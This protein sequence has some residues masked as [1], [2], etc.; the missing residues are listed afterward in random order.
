LQFHDLNVNNNS[1]SGC[2]DL[3][4]QVAG[5]KIAKF[6]LGCFKTASNKV[7]ISEMKY[8]EYDL[9]SF[10]KERIKF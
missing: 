1:F 8:V 6:K 5:V 10:Q 3:I 2:I 7:F 4:A 9:E